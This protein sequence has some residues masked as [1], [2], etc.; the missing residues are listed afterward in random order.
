MRAA[1]KRNL[2]YS[3]ND[4]D[5][6]DFLKPIIE[7]PSGRRRE[8]KVVVDDGPPLVVEKIL[9]RKFMKD[10]D[11]ASGFSEMY[12]I[13][14]R[15]MSYIHVSWELKGDIERV[16]LQGK[17]KIKRFLQ[18][19]LP[20]QIFGDPSKAEGSGN[21]DGLDE[22]EDIEYFNPDYAEIHR[23]IS[24]DTPDTPHS[25]CRTVA[26]MES[27][28]DDPSATED[29][30]LYYVKWRGQPYN[31]CTWER[32]GDIKY[33]THEVFA[34]WQRQRPPKLSSFSVKHP[35]LQDYS[36]LVESPV[37]GALEEGGEA[38][39]EGGLTMR[40]YQMEGVN[41]LLWNWWHK[42]PCILADEM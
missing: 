40:D 9:G 29:D 24:C 18:S 28:G 11:E 17:V 16:D 5:L 42:R 33:Y 36:R 1:R 4:S 41:W 6:D 14:W 26:D 20:P 15:G 8:E 21:E 32:W 25:M 10:T 31:E 19:P 3:E 22:E 39:R 38:R 27:M 37:Y 23:I 2:K 34:F 13:K 7:S 12:L 30:I 35:A